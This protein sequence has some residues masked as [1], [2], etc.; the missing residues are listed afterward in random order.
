MQTCAWLPL[1][2]DV[3]ES[4]SCMEGCLFSPIHTA[5]RRAECRGYYLSELRS[6]SHEI[7]TYTSNILPSHTSNMPLD[8]DDDE[9]VAKLLAQDAKNTTKTYDLVGLDAF[10]PKRCVGC[11]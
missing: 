4:V 2:S 6:Y 11:L 1:C 3:D 7:K 10:N 9:Y 5:S 8:I